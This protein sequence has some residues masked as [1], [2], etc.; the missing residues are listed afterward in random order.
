MISNH[1]EVS[2]IP[3]TEKNKIQIRKR[4]IL[5]MV[6]RKSKPGLSKLYS[7]KS[8]LSLPSIHKI[9]LEPQKLYDLIILNIEKNS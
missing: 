2:R 8:C 4:E 3:A 6:R 5:E 1:D 9:C 7:P